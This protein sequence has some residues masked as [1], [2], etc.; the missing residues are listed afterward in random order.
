[1]FFFPLKCFMSQGVEEGDELRETACE[2]R[3]RWKG[4]NFEGK[5][6]KCGCGVRVSMC[7]R[8]HIHTTP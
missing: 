5:N 3:E 8:K 1:M 2:R 6:K 7:E 4:L